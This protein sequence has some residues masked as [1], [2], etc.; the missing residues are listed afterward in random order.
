MSRL[1]GAGALAG[2]YLLETWRAKPTLFWNLAFPL[3]TLML[4]S[5]IFGGG[6]PARVARVLPGTMTINLL[7]A[8]FFGVSLHMVSLRERQLYRRFRVTPVDSLAVVM[9]HAATGFVNMVISFVLQLAVAKAVFHVPIRGSFADLALT[10]LVGAFAFIPLGLIVGSI[11]RDMRSA[12]AISNLLFFPLSFL[13]GATLPLFLMPPW[14][15]RVA[16]LLPSTYFVELLTV[17]L[18]RGRPVERAIVSLAILVL[19]GIVAFALNAWLFRWETAQPLNRRG[20]ALSLGTLAVIYGTA[21]AYGANLESARATESSYSQP[22]DAIGKEARVLFGMTVIDG[23][24][25]RIDRAQI[26]LKGKRIVAVG[27]ASAA[28]SGVAVTDLSGLYVIPGLIDSHV[29]LGGSAGGSVTVEEYVPKRLVHD[30]QAYLASGVTVLVS[31]TDPVEDMRKL[32]RDVAAGSMRAPHVYLS[33][34]GITAVGGHPARMFSFL[35]GFPEYMTR[36]VASPQEAGRAVAELTAMP[37]DIV[38]L[39]VEAGWPGQSMPILPE[40]ALRAAIR[41]ARERGVKT[42]VH[43]DGDR[44]AQL[45]IDAGADA[46]EHVPPDLSDATIGVLVARKVTLTPTLAVSESLAR[47]LSGRTVDDPLAQAWVEPAVLESLNAEDS[48][49]AAV[50]KSQ[51]TV[52]YYVK[53]FEQSR[54]ALRRA[55]AGKVTILAGSDAGNAGVFHGPG[56]IR[57]LELL[58][59]EGGMTPG[60][61]IRAATGDAAQRLGTNDMGRI[62]PG[63]FADLVVLERDPGKD[64]RALRNVRAVYFGGAPLDRNRLLTS[65]PGPWTPTF[66]FPA[67]NVPPDDV[68]RAPAKR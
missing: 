39:F 4:F 44:H 13:S 59:Q 20:L 63:A 21:F 64:I 42:T 37:V 27:P 53:R 50:R 24:G 67:P 22:A 54:A 8:A 30:L 40:P 15:Q 23:V 66:S 38:K 45:A 52:D 58:V 49:I 28:P 36:Q 12:P 25:G 56:L 51:A 16:T 61:A 19:T 57:E 7:A 34:P 33:G 32:Q 11:G 10:V 17:A 46:I 5:F 47:L 9:A 31:L 62:A 41:A 2:A 1:R 48:W 14:L 43:V 18:L 60:A 65:N 55:V 29:H 26:T 35:P 68:K 3:L 6:E